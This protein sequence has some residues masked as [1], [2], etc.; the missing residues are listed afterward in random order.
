MAAQDV[1]ELIPRVRRAIEGPAGLTTG[2]LQDAQ[3]EALAADCIADIIL[4]TGGQWEHTLVRE[5][6]GGGESY[7]VDPPLEL[8]EESM[9][10][11][12]AALTY[13]FHQYKD[14]K[15]SERVKNEAQEW[16]YSSSAQLMRDYMKVLVDMRDKALAALLRTTP[17]LAR[18]ASI[19]QV[20]D[21]VASAVLEPWVGGGLGGGIELVQ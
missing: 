5:V 11:A 7:T 18:Y 1:A 20:R 19:L 9:V 14:A 2:A 15:T 17:V 12:Q 10:A 8:D 16:E 13:F 21:R 4:L 3:V 6:D